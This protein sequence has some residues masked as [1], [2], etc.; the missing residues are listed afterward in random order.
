MDDS[1]VPHPMLRLPLRRPAGCGCPV[2]AL[3]VAILLALL[4]TGY[5][6]TRGGRLAWPLPR[7]V[8][9]TPV[10]T[11]TALPPPVAASWTPSMTPVAPPPATATGTPFPLPTATAVSTSTATPWP[12]STLR[13]TPTITPSPSPQPTSTLPVPTATSRAPGATLRAPTATI[14]VP[15]ATVPTPAA[16]SAETVACSAEI[17]A[18]I[19]RA[20][21]AQA[22]YMEGT[23]DEAALAAA[24]GG[25]AVD[26]Q[27]EADRLLAFSR[28][29]G[30]QVEIEDVIW[31]V[32]ECQMQRQLGWVRVVTSERWTYEAAAECVPGERHA[33]RRIERFPAQ[34]YA[35]SHDGEEWRIDSWLTGPAEVE[36]Q[37]RCPS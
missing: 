31:T 3:A 1:N 18:V 8:A 24:W 37:W 33:V 12:T 16:T 22:Q 13:A 19:E 30:Q 4:W 15:T 29:S 34:V 32:S 36:A 2:V 5:A 35:L 25:A 7:I 14:A 23:L 21:A 20:A 6:W 9:G 27:Q 11:E 17:R 28:A 10:V 26:A